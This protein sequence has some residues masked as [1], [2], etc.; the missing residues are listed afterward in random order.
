[1]NRPRVIHIGKYYPPYRGGMET[2]IQTICNQLRP[3]WDARA[4]VAND[5]RESIDECVEGVPVSRVGTLF[6]LSAAPLCPGMVRKIREAGPGLMHV[7]VPNP[8]AVMAY[9]ASGHRGPLIVSYQ[10]DTV[11]QKFLGALFSPILK[12]LLDRASAIIAASPNYIESSPVLA[13]YRD[14]CRV[15]PYG[16]DTTPFEQ[17]D[18][19]QAAR[20]AQRYGPRM[21][22][23]VGR[24]VYYKGFEYLIRAIRDVADAQLVIV[25][26][27]PLE[28]R[29][30]QLMEESG[31]AGRV[32]LLGHVENLAPYYHA[33]SMFVLPSIARSEAFG[34]VQLEAMA[35]SKP[36]INTALASGVPYVSLDG[37]T[38]ITVPP[39]DAQA[40]AAAINCLLDNS[41]LRLRYGQA[42]R[43][44]LE[45]EFTL[46][47]MM[48]RTTNLYREYS[49]RHTPETVTSNRG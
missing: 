37:V 17:Y 33:A 25:G 6:S 4:I 43:R 38:G 26:S 28:P 5:G 49:V 36:V 30:R 8:G 11:R 32:H 44:R 12:R 13:G 18:H 31:V 46:D 2:Y 42:A 34:I 3:E 22:L 48:R 35:C 40:M 9:L 23:S 10:S 39:A 16:I 27:G 14:R 21:V 20:L 47:D 45:A 7:H 1:M 15:I 29:L 24:L 41:D 19:A